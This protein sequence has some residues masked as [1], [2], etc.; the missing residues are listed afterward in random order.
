MTIQ[1]ATSKIAYAGAGTTGPF[2]IPWLFYANTDITVYTTVVST[3]VI[4]TLVNAV[5][6][7][8]TG[9]GVPA[10]GTCTTTS[11]VAVGTTITLALTPPL[12]QLSDY[13]SGE[14]FPSA[15]LEE[16]L[17]REVQIAQYLQNQISL[18]V[19]APS[20]EVS[21]TMTLPAVATRA[22]QYLAFD[23]SG[24]VTVASGVGTDT[25]LRADLANTTTAG[26]GNDLI[27]Y[28]RT[29]AE[30]AASVTPVSYQYPHGDIEFENVFR[31]LDTA[32]IALISAG[33]TSSQTAATVTTGVQ[34]SLTVYRN[35]F[36]PRGNYKISSAI[37]I[38]PWTNFKGAGKTDC[39]VW[40]T[41]GVVEGTR[42]IQSAATYAIS[43]DIGTTDDSL[44]GHV[45]ISDLTVLGGR[46]NEPAGT[47]E[48]TPIGTYGIRCNSSDFMTLTNVHAAFFTLS[49]FRFLGSLNPVMNRCEAQY[50]QDCG[51][52]FSYSA[53]GTS[54]TT[55]SYITA[56]NGGKFSQNKNAGIKVDTSAVRMSFRDFDCESNGGFYSTGT[57]YGLY[58]LGECRAIE[59]SGAWFEG[60]K[61][62]IVVGDMAASP[63]L[64]TTTDV[65]VIRMCE[66]G[67]T[68][69]GGAA[70][71]LNT[72]INTIIENNEFAAGLTINIGHFADNP[73]IRENTGNPIV[74]DG[75]SNKLTVDSKDM[76]NN[77]PYLDLTTWTLTNCTVAK[78]YVSSPAGFVPVYKVTPSSVAQV[79]LQSPNAVY[80]FLTT[81][82]TIGC[83]MRSDA[84]AALDF[85]PLISSV[86][87][88]KYY[89]AAET[90]VW[91]VTG[92]WSWVSIGRSIASTDTGNQAFTFVVTPT[93]T[94][95]FYITGF[96]S[97][98]GLCYAPY[99]LPRDTYETLTG[100]GA[101]SLTD[102]VTYLVT[103]GANALTLADGVNGQSK[104]IIMKT[105]GG[106]GT[107][108]PANLANGTTIT[109][110]DVDD[111]AKLEFAN[112]QWYMVGGTAT[113]A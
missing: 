70:I 27:S 38:K 10:G 94:D 63:S 56:I 92:K 109:F 64:V 72:G 74:T 22:S 98:T 40:S 88:G 6:Y 108:T 69:G 3:G 16:D 4:T 2:T 23:A 25:A 102:E 41:T 50:N 37:T 46:L 80:G 12:T 53:H 42:I 110:N 66:F 89:T 100:A 47:Y 79:Q 93:T 34:N 30:T 9:A 90:D 95:P 45:C 32:S 1:S 112:G 91:H 13:V 33:T 86:G 104:L 76:T 18:A 106:D 51:V 59:V 7:N 107:L 49:G 113:L 21:P 85:W 44:Y 75:N 101:V 20:S 58:L 105:D 54:E 96:S 62:H 11:N 8:L 19:R 81:R 68:N 28:R 17:D 82:Q 103:T 71:Q 55:N 24:N 39:Y 14:T 48:I 99:I 84:A 87:M 15:T 111:F 67:S 52:L 5:D 29:T 83:Y 61:I 43:T 36:A 97:R 60:N 65:L 77:F 31:Q 35:S 78:E 57:G 26:K 73:I